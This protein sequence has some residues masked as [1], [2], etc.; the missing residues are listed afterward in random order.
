MIVL[1][2]IQ[3]IVLFSGLEPNLYLFRFVKYEF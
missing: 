1:N 2:S 3:R